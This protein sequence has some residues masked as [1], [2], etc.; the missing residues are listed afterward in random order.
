[1]MVK[2]KEH[3]SEVWRE[4]TKSTWMSPNLRPGGGK[5]WI[6][7]LVCL[8]LFEAWQGWQSWHH[9]PMPRLMPFKTKR[10]ATGWAGTWMAQAV[11]G[12][13]GVLGKSSGYNGTCP[14]H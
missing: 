13:K 7:A 12:A 3:T 11:E 9:C 10:L 4:P 8:T 2:R 1:M 5:W 14:A 6:G